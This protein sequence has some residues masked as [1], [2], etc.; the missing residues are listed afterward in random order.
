MILG[1]FLFSVIA[2]AEVYSKAE[3]SQ[4][5]NDVKQD[6]ADDNLTIERIIYAEGIQSYN[7]QVVNGDKIWVATGPLAA[8]YDYNQQN[9][10]LSDKVGTHYQ[11]QKPAWEFF[12]EGRVIAQ[13]AIATPVSPGD[14][15]WLEVTLQQE[16]DHLDYVRV[17]SY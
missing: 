1:V 17:Y 2:N 16:A 8:L 10:K 12:G 15:A 9:G 5:V 11:H 14:V 6:A 7:L 13:S 3:L 4:I